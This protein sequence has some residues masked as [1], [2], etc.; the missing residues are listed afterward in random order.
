M[1]Y[2]YHVSVENA[3]KMNTTQTSGNRRTE[4]PSR[5]RGTYKQIGYKLLIYA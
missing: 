5:E 4:V 1:F 2:G 3:I